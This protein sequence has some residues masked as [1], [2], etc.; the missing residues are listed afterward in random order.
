M[1]KTT[2]GELKKNYENIIKNYHEKLEIE[3]LDLTLELGVYKGKR[4]EECN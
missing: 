3:I 2:K 1:I 4:C